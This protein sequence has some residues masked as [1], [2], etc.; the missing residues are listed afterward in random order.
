MSENFLI[1][2]H[3]KNVKRL[4]QIGFEFDNASAFSMNGTMTK[5]KKSFYLHL[6]PID[7]IAL[8]NDDTSDVSSPN[9]ISDTCR[10]WNE[11]LDAL[12]QRKAIT[13]N[14]AQKIR[15]NYKGEDD[16]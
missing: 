12:V 2:N 4:V 7:G 13:Q 1:D 11:L 8:L 16:E 5:R 10:T 14:A 15:D 3:C 9:F 6:F